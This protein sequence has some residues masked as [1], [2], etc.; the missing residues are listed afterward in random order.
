MEAVR[1]QVSTSDDELLARLERFCTALGRAT[2][3]L[4]TYA[5][6]K[7]L[8]A[9]ALTSLARHC[10]RM[11]EALEDAASVA[12]NEPEPLLV[13]VR[14]RAGVAGETRRSAHLVRLPVGATEL[15]ESF[16]AL[17]GIS[18]GPGDVERLDALHGMPC[19]TC[20]LASPQ[21]RQAEA[22]EPLVLRR[23]RR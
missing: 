4:T 19:S 18:F 14:Y 22:N 20:L 21:R 6:A 12:E 1:G 10:R 15:P 11:A 8:P 17:C 5:R 3:D 13:P 9:E 2:T 16:E 23:F 7:P